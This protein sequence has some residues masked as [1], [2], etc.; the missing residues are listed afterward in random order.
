M[1]IRR[2]LLLHL[3]DSLKLTETSLKAAWI[4]LFSIFVQAVVGV[5]RRAPMFF[6]YCFDIDTPQLMKN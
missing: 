3:L 2:L 5:S 4:G 1:E 6:Y